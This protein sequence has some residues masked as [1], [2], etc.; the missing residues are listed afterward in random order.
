MYIYISINQSIKSSKRAS[1]QAQEKP[2]SSATTRAANSPASQ[3]WEA[4][5]ESRKRL[6]CVTRSM[7]M[8]TRFLHAFYRSAQKLPKK[9]TSDVLCIIF[10]RKKKETR[11]P[12]IS[13]I[14]IH[15]PYRDNRCVP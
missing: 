2:H 4:K 13:P 11:G 15:Y 3:S 10:T 7:F 14:M 9:N 1:T 8:F 12:V 6:A 5:S